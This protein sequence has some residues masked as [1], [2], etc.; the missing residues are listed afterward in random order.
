MEGEIIDQALQE[1]IDY[2]HTQGIGEE[3][4]M[5]S[6]P[7]VLVVDFQKGLTDS[8]QPAG[9]N[10]D[11]EVENTV[12]IL[13]L[14][15]KKEIPVVFTVIAYHHTLKDG[16]LLVKKLPVLGNYIEN[17]YFTEVDSRL[18]VQTSEPI[19]VKKYGSSFFGTT[20]ASMLTCQGI[21]TLII[22]GC[23]TSGCVRATAVDA[24]QH[25]FRAVIPRECVA[26]RSKIPHE[27]S[28]MDLHA[29]YADVISLK[30]V[31]S[32]LYKLPDHAR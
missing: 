1:I 27:V 4:G 9:V 17:S 28:L 6:S 2:Y 12:E 19:I 30:R 29:R 16:G 23:T 20:L 25:G 24:M 14:A 15:R 13:K 32:Y 26:D 22:T 11:K 5:G 7:A 21:D 31:L 8:T 10:M 3:L 18:Q